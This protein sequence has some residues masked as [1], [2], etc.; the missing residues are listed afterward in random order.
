M[1]FSRPI[2][3]R[4][5]YSNL[6]LISQFYLYAWLQ[7]RLLKR[8]NISFAAIAKNSKLPVYQ[9]VLI[10]ENILFDIGQI[11]NQ[12]RVVKTSLIA[13]KS[14]ISPAFSSTWAYFTIPSLSITKADRLLTPFISNTKVS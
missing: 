12:F 6:Q 11:N 4:S 14:G 13:L 9:A 7:I 10:N 2:Q 8:F 3:N 1:I 5:I